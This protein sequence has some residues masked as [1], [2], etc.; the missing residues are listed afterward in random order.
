MQLLLLTGPD[1]VYACFN[2]NHR[3]SERNEIVYDSHPNI[4]INQPIK[5]RETENQSSFA[6]EIASKRSKMTLNQE[7]TPFQ[8]LKTQSWPARVPPL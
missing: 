6:P 4:Q 3:K 1:S 8:S 5:K 2:S 7:T